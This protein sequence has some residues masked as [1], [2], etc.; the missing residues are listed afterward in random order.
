M[1][2]NDDKIKNIMLEGEDLTQS[3][4]DFINK[5]KEHWNLKILSEIKGGYVK[6]ETIKWLVERVI[7]NTFTNT[8]DFYNNSKTINNARSTDII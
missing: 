6:S 4:I 1:A 3:E 2:L 5:G 7:E 8:R